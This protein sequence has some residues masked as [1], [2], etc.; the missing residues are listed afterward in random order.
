MK[1]I[2]LT[3]WS[4]AGKTTHARQLAADLQREYVPM[5][6]FMRKAIATI[7]P[8]AHRDLG[9]HEWEPAIDATRADSAEIDALADALI[10]RYLRGRSNVVVDAW[11]QPWIYD[12][13]AIRIWVESDLAS[14]CMK[15][16]VSCLREGTKPDPDP[17]QYLGA[18]DAFSRRTFADM[19]GINFGPSEQF[20]IHFD[21]SR[22]ITEPTIAASDAGIRGS[23]PLLLADVISLQQ[24]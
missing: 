6:P 12:G 16:I 5:A 1:A 3:G 8:S 22:F 13:P 17:T 20:D 14:R 24:Y 18:K 9:A 10:A 15:Y 2:L 4:A 7:S 23:S 19:Y 21:N 11:L